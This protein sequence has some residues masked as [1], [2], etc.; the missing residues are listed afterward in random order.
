MYIFATRLQDYWGDFVVIDRKT[1]DNECPRWMGNE[2]NDG[3]K[4]LLRFK[5]TSI[6]CS[7]SDL[8]Q[9]RNDWD[10]HFPIIQH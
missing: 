9:Y 1:L 10:R 7:Q 8:S 2:N 6:I 3:L 4:L 5:E